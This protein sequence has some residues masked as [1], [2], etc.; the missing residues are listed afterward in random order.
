MLY[1]V[2]TVELEKHIGF[3]KI[4][5]EQILI[6]IMKA[7]PMYYLMTNLVLWFLIMQKHQLAR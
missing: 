4:V 3:S 7:I 2:V 5:M 1:K 6:L